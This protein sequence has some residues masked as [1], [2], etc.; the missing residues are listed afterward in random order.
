MRRTIA[1][2]L[3]RERSFMKITGS[4][5][6]RTISLKVVKLVD[7]VI[8]SRGSANGSPAAPAIALPTTHAY[9]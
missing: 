9:S 1:Q 5:R 6:P 3:V 4:L 7:R 2:P 8:V